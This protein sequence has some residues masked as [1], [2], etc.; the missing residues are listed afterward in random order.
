MKKNCST[1]TNDPQFLLLGDSHAGAIGRAAK[2]AGVPF[3]GGPMGAGR[4]FTA[5]FVDW[6]AETLTF[7]SSY[8]EE[9]YQSFLK[10][11]NASSLLDVNL[12][13]L[14][15]FGFALHFYATSE[16]W[17]I[18]R[19][20][21]HTLSQSF[22]ES[23]LFHDLICVMAQGALDFYRSLIEKG[24]DVTAILPPQKVPETS[25]PNVFRAAQS[26]LIAE[27]NRM[28]LKTLDV[29]QGTVGRDGLQLDDFSQENDPIHG[30]VAFGQVLLDA[31]TNQRTIDHVTA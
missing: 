9:M 12:P 25:D 22:L 4:E 27:A 10:E 15:T 2:E 24:I 3:V 6:D 14:C 1:T 21:D 30:N 26:V 29:R 7:H 31:F 23:P 16:N 8:A 20:A 17:E 19:E 13:L 11:L 28:G 5:P 18:Y